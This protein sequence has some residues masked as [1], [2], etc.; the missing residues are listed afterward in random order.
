MWVG[1]HVLLLAAWIQAFLFPSGLK[2]IMDFIPNHSSDRH[3]WFNLSRTRDPLYEDYYVWADCNAT[4]KP[5][6]WVCSCTGA[7][8][9]TIETQLEKNKDLCWSLSCWHNLLFFLQVSIFGNSS[10]TYDEVRGQCYLH[11]FLKEQ[12]D[13]NMRNPA[14]RKEIIV[15]LLEVPQLTSENDSFWQMFCR[16]LRKTVTVSKLLSMDVIICNK[17][18]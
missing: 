12:P 17:Q 5:N 15:R 7:L 14:V 18:I 8:Y 2:L 9:W 13:L 6:N 16:T 1:W 3:R 10:W 4:K 11:Q